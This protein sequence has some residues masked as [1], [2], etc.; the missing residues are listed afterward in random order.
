VVNYR[1]QAI[2]VVPRVAMPTIEAASG[3]VED[4]VVG[5]RPAFFPSAA[6]G[7]PDGFVDTPVYARAKL[8]AGHRIAGPAIVEQYDSTVVV[9]PEQTAEV[10]GYGNLLITNREAN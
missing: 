6:G 3:P 1:V 8:L 2:G 10:D 5:S 7:A 4:A 9:F